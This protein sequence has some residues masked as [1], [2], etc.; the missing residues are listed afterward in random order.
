MKNNNP[1]VSV[2]VPV[3]NTGKYLKKCIKSI[4]TQRIN[5]LEIIIVNDC[6]TDKSLEIINKIAENDP[7]IIIVNK[8]VNEGLE[9]ARR[10]G[11]EL[12]NGD[13]FYH[14]DSDDWLVPNTL[15]LLVNEA[16]ESNADI[17]IA[18]FYRTLDGFGI[19]KQ[20]S[21]VKTASKVLVVKD[22]F[23]KNYYKNFF[24]INLFPVSMC[25]KLYKKSFLRNLETELLGF[26]LGEDLNYNIQVFPHATK[27]LFFPTFVYNYRFGGMTTKLN[28]NLMVAAL[29]MYNIKKSYLL[30]YDLKNLNKFIIYELKNYLF[31]SI[32][33]QNK[34]SVPYNIIHKD[35]E[36]LLRTREFGDVLSYYAK[37]NQDTDEFVIAMLKS[38]ISK[39]FQIAKEKAD[40]EFVMDFLKKKL[41][42][43]LIP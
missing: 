8:Q 4:L 10:A 20:K 33:I 28:D 42:R 14:V 5:N 6:S 15:H 18:N 31:T 26:N 30:K 25:G 34:F 39:L 3:F 17:V 40:K 11:L 16:I 23:I 2:I 24:G 29:K 32:L 9:L 37:A 41:S 22:D 36:K 1:Q 19:I 27:I 43:L 35:V 38:D 13:Y 7:R 21:K 12:A